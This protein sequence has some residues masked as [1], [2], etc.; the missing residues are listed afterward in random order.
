MKFFLVVYDR[1]RGKLVDLKTFAEPQ[2]AAALRARFQR[3][4][5]ERSR[6]EIEVVLLGAESLDDLKRT[7]ARYFSSLEEL[8]ASA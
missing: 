5:A 6:P 3:E 4:T 1:S 8:A 7:H 2:R